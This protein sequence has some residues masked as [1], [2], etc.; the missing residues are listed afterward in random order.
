MLMFAPL[1]SPK[2]TDFITYVY[3]SKTSGVYFYKMLNKEGM[4]VGEMK[5]YPEVIYDKYRR[6]SP[7]ADVYRS[8]FIDRLFAYKKGVGIG[9]AFINIAKRES[10]RK[11]CFGNIHTV[12]SSVFD[13][14]NPPYIFFR[15]MGFDFNKYSSKTRE[16]INDC[17]K[18]N[19]QIE[20]NKCMMDT[21]MF[22]DKCVL[23]QDKMFNKFYELRRKFP[24]I[25]HCL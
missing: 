2:I 24:E 5:A 3:R 16:Y 8:F 15:K 13:K 18:Q 14:Q 9:K 20:N 11:V 12:A 22:I 6:F 17:I 19:K 25:F 21:P 10:F 23:N 4:L 7:N 1:K